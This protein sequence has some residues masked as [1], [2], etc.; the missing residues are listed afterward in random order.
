MRHGIKMTGEPVENGGRPLGVKRMRA[1]HFIKYDLTRQTELAPVRV[2]M[3]CASCGDRGKL[4]CPAR[5]ESRKA[6]PKTLA[7]QLDLR[8][9]S[10]VV[11]KNR[12]AGARP[13]HCVVAV[14]IVN[15][16]LRVGGVNN[17]NL[18]LRQIPEHHIAV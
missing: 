18:C 12:Q 6:T 17:I 4:Q 9:D 7:R 5:P 3:T 11:V 1:P 13:K 15:A 16:A 14:E 10:G 8:G 2:F